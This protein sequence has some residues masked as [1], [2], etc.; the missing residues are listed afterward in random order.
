M[1]KSKLRRRI[2][3][4]IGGKKTYLKSDYEKNV[5]ELSMA[6]R[7]AK[8]RVAKETGQDFVLTKP[9]NL[10]QKER[11]T[12]INSTVK[13][14]FPSYKKWL[15]QTNKGATAKSSIEYYKMKKRQKD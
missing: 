5:E 11:R 13:A 9:E 14:S 1:A 10:A 6:L 12:R 15:E 3:E 4:L 2:K 8:N 7:R